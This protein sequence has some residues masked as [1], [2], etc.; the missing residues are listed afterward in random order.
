M[1]D[2]YCYTLKTKTQGVYHLVLKNFEFA[3]FFKKTILFI[4]SMKI[5]NFITKF[6]LLSSY[7]FFNVKAFFCY[8]KNGQKSI[9]ELGKCFKTAKNAISQRKKNDLF[10]FKSCFA[11]TFLNFLARCERTSKYHS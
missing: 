7:L 9:F 2:L 1:K 6:L 10:D 3:R 4:G 11:W 5:H 8:Y